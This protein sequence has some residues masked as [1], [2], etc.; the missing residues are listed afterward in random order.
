MSNSGGTRGGRRLGR[1]LDCTDLVELGN[2]EIIRFSILENQ[3]IRPFFCLAWGLCL[4]WSVLWDLGQVPQ[5]LG[6]TVFSWAE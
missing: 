6:A 4:A 2:R 5:L 3:E 1:D